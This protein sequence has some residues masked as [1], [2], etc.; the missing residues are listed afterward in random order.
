MENMSTILYFIVNN[1]CKSVSE[2]SHKRNNFLLNFKLFSIKWILKMDSS[3][4][5]QTSSAIV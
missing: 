1:I 5:Y 4:E 3:I 2:K